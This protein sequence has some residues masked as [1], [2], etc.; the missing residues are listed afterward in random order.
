[1]KR[2]RERE[3]MPRKMKKRFKNLLLFFTLCGEQY[4]KEQE[5]KKHGNDNQ[6]NKI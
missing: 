6:G 3:K 5:R 4:K 2:K 1:M